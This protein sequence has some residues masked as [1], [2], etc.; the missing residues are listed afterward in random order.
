[1]PTSEDPFPD[2]PVDPD[3]TIEVDVPP[4]LVHTTAVAVIAVGG[5]LGA[6]GRWAVAEALPHAAGR[7]PWDTFLTN[8]SGCFLI[9]V[10]MVLV[11]E[12]VTHKPL[13]RPF[14]G[15]GVLGG[16]TT[17]STYIVDTQRAAA[18][19]APLVALGYLALTLLAALLSVYTG[20]VLTRAAVHR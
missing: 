16:Y 10:L 2:F 7:F 18:E 20:T 12:V 19:G 9:G 11:T 3:V 14:L 5:S 15:V 6:L 13:L 17:F 4:P 1:M 8:V